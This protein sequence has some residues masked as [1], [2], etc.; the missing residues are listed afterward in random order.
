MPARMKTSATPPAAALSSCV[1]VAS[2]DRALSV[3]VHRVE[4]LGGAVSRR[5]A[6]SKNVPPVSCEIVLQRRRHRPG[7]RSAIEV[8][9]PADLERLRHDPARR[10]DGDRVDRDRVDERGRPR[11]PPASC[12]RRSARR[13]RRRTTAPGGCRVA[14]LALADGRGRRRRPTADRRR[15]STVPPSGVIV[16]RAAARSRRAVEGRR[17]DE[18]HLVAERDDRD[19]VAR[20]QLVQEPDRQLLARHG[21]ASAGRRRRPSSRRRRT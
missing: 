9:K 19:L 21:D 2:C 1:A 17:D 3:V 12:R 6:A 5:R 20:R 4:R 15:R 18:V 14:G 13:P 7:P 11:P 8:L 16:G 10:P